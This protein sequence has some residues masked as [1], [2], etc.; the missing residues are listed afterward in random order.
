MYKLA[1]IG[2]PIAHSM[3]PTVF[4]MFARELGVDLVYEKLLAKDSDHFKQIVIDFFQ[5]GGLALNITSPFK[6]DAFEVAKSVTARAGFCLAANFLR[7]D[8][9]NEILADTTDG[10]GLVADIQINKGLNLIG[11]NILILGSG[12]VLDSVLLDLIVNNP[13]SIDVLARNQ[14]RVKYLHN[15]FGINGFIP[16]KEYDIILNTVPNHVDNVMLTQIK[17]LK[18][19]SS[20][21]DMAY[22]DLMTNKFYHYV[23]NLNAK[24]EVHSGIGMLVEQA[25]VAFEK[26]F[27][28][29]PN[30]S[31]VI[32]QISKE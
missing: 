19:E 32:Q 15:K 13:L 8:N 7:L 18:N 26:L 4:S 10:V 23:K 31:K 30:V 25:K 9:N 14:E 1:V 2:N 27:N 22:S 29:T 5:S 11:K 6:Q 24:V 16:A 20:C 21:Y 17:Q 3:S 12:F 28:L